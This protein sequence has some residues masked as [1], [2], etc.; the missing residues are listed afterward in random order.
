MQIPIVDYRQ[1]D[2]AA[3]FF[4]SIKATGFGVLSNTFIERSM[5]DDAYQEWRSFFTMNIESKMK[6]K[7][8]PELQDGYFPMLSEKAKDAKLADLK[9]FIHHFPNRKESTIKVS[10]AT[11][12]LCLAL[13]DLAI[14]ILEWL[15]DHAPKGIPGDWGSMVD[16]SQGTLYR[17]IHY[18]PITLGETK[19]GAVRAAAHEDINFITLLPAATDSGLEVLDRNGKWHAVGTDSSSI[20]VN[21]GDM[22]ELMTKGFYKSTTHRVVNPEGEANG[23]SRY[24]M[25]L[26]LHPH[27]NTQ[28][29][30]EKTAGQ[31]LNERLKELGLI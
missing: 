29:S 12:N 19:D 7:F 14:E 6:F 10:T 31:Y 26:F 11:E 4:Q 17:V 28:L 30:P 23:R 2:A 8:N 5:V 25:P 27:S 3:R 24:S 15:E 18:P 16:K 9:E 1:N 22:L 13:E 20:I 21:I